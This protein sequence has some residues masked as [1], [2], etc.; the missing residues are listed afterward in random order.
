MALSWCGGSVPNVECG[1]LLI[2][3]GD[4]MDGQNTYYVNELRREGKCT[5]S[6]LITC[7]VPVFGCGAHPALPRSS[8]GRRCSCSPRTPAHLASGL[9]P[10]S[11]IRHNY[12]LTHV[13]HEGGWIADDTYVRWM[14]GKECI[15]LFPLPSKGPRD[16]VFYF[17]PTMTGWRVC[18]GACS[19]ILEV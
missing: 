7:C 2:V 5:I 15:L 8:T 6:S 10:A 11:K 4:H 9:P 16:S 18:D 19:L 17:S 3:S 13:V 1:T 12:V 14:E